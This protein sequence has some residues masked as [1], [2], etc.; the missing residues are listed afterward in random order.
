MKQ[1][2][3]NFVQRRQFLTDCGIGLGRCALLSLLGGTASK[4]ASAAP[5]ADI[6]VSHLPPFQA[7]A[8]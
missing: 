6:A 1:D 2:L 4:T 8:K 5:S 7:K 3:L